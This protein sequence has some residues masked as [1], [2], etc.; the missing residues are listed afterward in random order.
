MLHTGTGLHQIQT[1]VGSIGRAS[2][3]TGVGILLTGIHIDHQRCIARGRRTRIAAQLSGIHAL[4]G[5]DIAVCIAH[6]ALDCGIVGIHRQ[7]RHGI[8]ICPAE[9]DDGI[10]SRRIAGKLDKGTVG[11][12]RIV[13]VTRQR[14]RAGEAAIA[15]QDEAGGIV[16]G[17][18]GVPVEHT[19]AGEA[20]D[21]PDCLPGTFIQRD[22]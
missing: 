1:G 15:L 21:I 8:G 20:V 9:R 22:L 5:V 6:K 19:L 17:G 11:T 12:G 16:V 10:L 3:S 2:Q 4:T 18:F 13:T 14:N 7:R